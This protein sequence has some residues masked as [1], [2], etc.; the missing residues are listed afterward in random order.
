MRVMNLLVIFFLAVDIS[1]SLKYMN[2]WK[3]HRIYKNVKMSQK[4]LVIYDISHARAHTHMHAH[5]FTE[6]YAISF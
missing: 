1:W 6:H 4:T 5:P 2:K 3:S